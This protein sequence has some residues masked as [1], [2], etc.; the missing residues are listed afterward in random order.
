MITVITTIIKNNQDGTE[1]TVVTEEHPPALSLF[2]V[3]RETTPTDE[4]CGD[5]NM[6]TEEMG[7]DEMMSMSGSGEDSGMA[8]GESESKDGGDAAESG[9][10]CAGCCG[11]KNDV[12]I[13][14][15]FEVNMEGMGGASASASSGD[16]AAS[17]GSMTSDA[18]T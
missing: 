15:D 16:S 13:A 3:S 18:S 12:K 11:G 7:A 17:S 10:A 1:T 9:C 14:I 6:M 8:S 4:T 2:I 5:M